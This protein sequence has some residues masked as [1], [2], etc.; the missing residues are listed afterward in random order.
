LEVYIAGEDERKV[1][2]VATQKRKDGPV[3]RTWEQRDMGQT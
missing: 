3:G 2:R 1:V